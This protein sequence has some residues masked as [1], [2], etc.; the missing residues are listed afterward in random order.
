MSDEGTNSAS[1]TTTAEQQVSSRQRLYMGLTKTGTD[2]FS[3]FYTGAL[4]GFYVDVL[5]M[6]PSSYG[7]VMIIFA[8]WNAIN[9]P[10]FG[11]MS[12]KKKLDVKGKGKRSYFIRLSTPIFFIGYVMLWLAFPSWS[13]T[14][15][16][17]FLL[18]SLFVFD[19]GLTIAGL[20]LSALQTD[21]TT[22]TNERTRIILIA[23]LISFVPLG[24][25][26][27]A[28]GLVL[29]SPAL[30]SWHMSL[31]FIAAGVVAVAFMAWGAWKLKEHSLEEEGI[32][33]LPIFKAIKETFKSKSFIFFVIFSFMM[34][35]VNLNLIAVMPLYYKYVFGLDS[36]Q[37][38]IVMAVTGVMYIPLLFAY[39]KLQKRFG[40]R[41]TFFIAL[42][43]M[44][45]GYLGLY[46]VKSIVLLIISYGLCLWMSSL[47][48]LLVNPM[49]GDIADEDE[50]RTKRRR[51]GMFF[52]TNAL[53]TKPA[54][55]L[56]I[57]IFTAMIG[58]Y[59][60]GNII[61]GKF[62]FSEISGL[63]GLV[64]RFGAESSVTLGFRLGVGIL[65]L[66][67]IVIAFVALY[68]YPLHGKK[69]KQVKSDLG[70]YHKK[71]GILNKISL[72]K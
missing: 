27:F 13:Q 20:N 22:N 58:F 51:E 64:S 44:V 43:L 49:V 25:A 54:S 21:Q 52:G 60:Y 38:F 35:A 40:L 34:N 70:A 32:E 61:I 65:P 72:E 5:H 18:I 67:F 11:Y 24:V 28:P 3:V 23:M 31:I 55:S 9:D 15:L 41:N 69:L 47:W 56:I 62:N 36:M 16:F 14:W 17:V 8:I 46:F 2:M 7:I 6:N 19:T 71:V 39:E 4:F 10:V 53:V 48:W 68:F 59:G 33:P 42:V 12:D 1:S 30:K 29:T 57:F 63:S 50:L 26:S 37:I 45:V 66:I